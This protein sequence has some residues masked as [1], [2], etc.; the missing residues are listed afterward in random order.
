MYVPSR[1]VILLNVEVDVR[2]RSSRELAIIANFFVRS[3]LTTK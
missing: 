3:M 1:D 2:L